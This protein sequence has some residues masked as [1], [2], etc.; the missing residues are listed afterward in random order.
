MHKEAATGHLRLDFGKDSWFDLWHTHLDFLGHGNKSIK[1]RTEHIKAHIALYESLLKRLETFEKHFQSWIEI[2]E[3]D[4][5]LDAVYIHS[6]NPNEDNFPL[7]IANVSWMVE[8]PYYFKNLIDPKKFD[9]GQYHWGS[10]RHFV[11]QVK[12]LRNTF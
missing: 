12:Y 2:D 9:V 3:Q 11:I 1:I 10:Q 4:A 7:E 5:G 8:I 6:P